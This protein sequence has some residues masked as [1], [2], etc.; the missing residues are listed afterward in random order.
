MHI[1][2]LP[3][4]QLYEDLLEFSGAAAYRN[5]LAPWIEAHPEERDW[6]CA[7]GERTGDPFPPATIEDLRR[8]HALSRDSR[9]P[10]SAA[11]RGRRAGL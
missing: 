11:Q 1:D 2:Q 6:F 9:V 4:R 3:Y 5:V 10:L 8:P 7:F